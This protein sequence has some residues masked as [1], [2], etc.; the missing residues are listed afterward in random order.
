ML[1]AFFACRSARC[2]LAFKQY[3]RLILVRVGRSIPVQPGCSSGPAPDASGGAQMQT[4][5]DQN[6]A[7]FISR[8]FEVYYE[9]V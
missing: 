1:R 5:P 8:R 3:A 2:E 6:M 4:K 9:V 7:P